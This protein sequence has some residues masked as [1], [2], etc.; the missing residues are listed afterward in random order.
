[1]PCTDAQ[2]LILRICAF[3][4]TSKQATIKNYYSVTFE[5][6]CYLTFLDFI[7]YG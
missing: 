1:M 5:M 2:G 7:V 4:L 6:Q 3:K